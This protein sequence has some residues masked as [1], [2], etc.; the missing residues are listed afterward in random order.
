[1]KGHVY[2]I[3]GGEIRKGETIRIDNELKKLVS[4]N[5]EFVF[6][7]AASGDSLDYRNSMEAAFKDDFKFIAPTEKDGAEFARSVIHTASVIYLGGGDAEK[8]LARFEKWNLISSLRDALDRGVCLVGMSAGAQAISAW[9]VH[10]DGDLVEIRRGWG[11]IPVCVL[12]HAS[13]STSI[14]AKSIWENDSS[15]CLLPLIAIGEG[16][17][18]CVHPSSS[19]KIGDGNMWR[20]D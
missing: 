7:G 8:L 12:V 11:L 1:M 5:K 10:E 4:T 9:Y 13:R 20:F 19:R 17:A 15:A 18:W 16:A 6:F 14:R 3:G 2:L